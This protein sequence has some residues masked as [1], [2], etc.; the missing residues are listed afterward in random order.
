MKNFMRIT[1]F[2]AILC[3]GGCAAVYQ[4]YMMEEDVAK[5]GKPDTFHY[6]GS[7]HRT[8]IWH[9]AGG[10]YRS[11]RYERRYGYWVRVRTHHSTC[12]R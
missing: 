9:C 6:H 4:G 12:I 11:Y 7:T 8:Y 3:L 1:L 2:A 5:F 10:M